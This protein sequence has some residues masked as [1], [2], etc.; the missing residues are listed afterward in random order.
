MP[1]IGDLLNSPSEKEFEG[2]VYQ[3]RQPT[4]EEEGLFQRWLE[5][6]A[7][8]AIARRTY[9]DPVEQETDRRLLNQDIAAGEYE[10]GGP[11]AVK[12]INTPRGI[13]QIVHIICAPQGMTLEIAKR[14][15]NHHL[16]LIAAVLISKL[17]GADPKALGESLLKH[18]VPAD[19]FSS[20]SG[21]HPSTSP[22]TNSDEAPGISS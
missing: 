10:Y 8:D 17:P 2:V 12:A 15:V 7:Y 19:F 18:G 14:F 16:E 4:M 13:A 3:L 1:S 5:Q 22:L 6:R 9:Q 21:T 11:L 20:D